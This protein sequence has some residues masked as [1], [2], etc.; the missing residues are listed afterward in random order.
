MHIIKLAHT[1]SPRNRSGHEARRPHKHVEGGKQLARAR[2]IRQ[3]LGVHDDDGSDGRAY[4]PQDESEL[5][6]VYSD[7]LGQTVA[8]AVGSVVVR[9]G[10]AGIAE[11]SDDGKTDRPDG[12]A[13]KMPNQALIDVVID[14]SGPE[15][16]LESRVRRDRVKEWH[17]E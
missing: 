17:G 13:L 14:K 15:E 5:A 3:P 10:T 16:S 2:L 4:L 8:I 7:G 1:L 6:K 12:K 11:V 9:V